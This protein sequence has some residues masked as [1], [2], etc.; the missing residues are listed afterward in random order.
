MDLVK[1]QNM[2][3]F[4]I[5]MMQFLYLN[6]EVLI[7]LNFAICLYVTHNSIMSLRVKFFIYHC[8]LDISIILTSSFKIMFFLVQKVKKVTTDRLGNLVMRIHAT[9]IARS[10]MWECGLCLYVADEEK[11]PARPNHKSACAGLIV[12]WRCWRNSLP[13]KLN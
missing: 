3:N 2:N 1:G 5:L 6:F 12:A 13:T 7:K 11:W 8:S 9:S 10:R 4:I